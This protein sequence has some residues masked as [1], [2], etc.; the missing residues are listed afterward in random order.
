MD[1]CVIYILHIYIICEY[2]HTRYAYYILGSIFPEYIILY[3]CYILYTNIVY[4]YVHYIHTIFAYYIW[5]YVYY[6]HTIIL[7]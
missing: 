1:I 3:A 4:T 7:Y 2:I 5:I 6:I